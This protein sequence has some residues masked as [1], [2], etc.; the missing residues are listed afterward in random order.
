[1]PR[2]E[3]L[4]DMIMRL[5]TQDLDN[6]NRTPP[7]LAK[8]QPSMANLVISAKEILYKA[9]STIAES[10]GG[11]DSSSVITAVL[12]RL[13]LLDVDQGVQGNVPI[14]GQST[15]LGP[16]AEQRRIVEDWIPSLPSGTTS[17]Q[18]DSGSETTQTQMTPTQST[19][20][21]STFGG[22]LNDEDSEDD[23]EFEYEILQGCLDKGF[24]SYN[25][26]DWDIAERF[27]RRAIDA[28]KTLPLD[29]IVV[30]GIDMMDAQ[31]KI[32]VCALHQEKLDEADAEL[33]QLRM[34]RPTPNEP[35]N[36]TL[37]HILSI[38]FFAEICFQRKKLE[39]AH[40]WCRKVLALTRKCLGETPWLEMY[41]FSL[42]TSISATQ[43]DNVTA[44]V[45][46]DKA[47]ASVPPGSSLEQ[48]PEIG[49]ARIDSMHLKNIKTL[50][51]LPF[52]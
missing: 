27:I 41:C 3:M 34:A 51:V 14:A 39:E 16:S 49:A 35:R 30:K 42:L 9:K 46:L 50:S 1:M 32:A 48:D 23:D 4:A 6:A 8:E 40:K 29:K 13:D 22:E 36:I 19:P 20:V 38:Y 24:A 11:S 44:E 15:R 52:L 17:S 31:F 28:S 37:R 43:G 10:D 33:F 5:S 12:N 45:Y 47:E 7:V 2:V 21:M 26:G 18:F 25:N